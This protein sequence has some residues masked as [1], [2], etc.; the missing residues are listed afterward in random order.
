M[1]N[2][3]VALRL[4]LAQAAGCAQFMDIHGIGHAHSGRANLQVE[5]PTN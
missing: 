4:A 5:V 2:Q 3:E 1:P